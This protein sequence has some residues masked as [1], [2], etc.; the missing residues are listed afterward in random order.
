MH[1]DMGDKDK[2][3]FIFVTLQLLKKKRFLN[4]ERILVKAVI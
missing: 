1:Y 3:G 4:F 2:T